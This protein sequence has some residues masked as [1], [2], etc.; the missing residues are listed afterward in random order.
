MKLKLFIFFLCFIFLLGFLAYQWASFSDHKLHIVVCDIGQGDGIYIRTP[1]GTDILIDAGPNDSILDCLSRHMPMWDRTIELAFATHPDADHI[2]G[3]AYVLK[4]YQVLSFNTSQRSSNT[5]IYKTIQALLDENKIPKKYLFSGDTYK[6]QDGVVLRT[7]WP[8]HVFVDTDTSDSTNRYS[9][10]Q[11][12]SYGHFKALFTGDIEADIL[13][14]LFKN[15]LVLDVFKIPHH[16]SKTGVDDM[17]FH[18]IRASFVPI[19]S[20]LHNRYH[21]PNPLV[22]DLLKKYKIPYKNTAEVGDIEIVTDGV[23]TQVID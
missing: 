11:T 22:L 8:T 15:G 12:L 18:L 2:G 10:V 7:Y 16:G 23:H 3:F 9:L 13:D 1:Q 21:H 14:N 20:G 17:T 4:S 5:G 19:S 6:I